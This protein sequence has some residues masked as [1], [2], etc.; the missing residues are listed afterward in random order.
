[1]GLLDL[2]YNQQSSLEIRG[3]SLEDLTILLPPPI[4]Q[5]EAPIMDALGDPS[6]EGRLSVFP[7]ADLLGFSSSPT[8]C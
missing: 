5:L 8:D 1:M 2:G 7:Q 4:P 6:T 3:H